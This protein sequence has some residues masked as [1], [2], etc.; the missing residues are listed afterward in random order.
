L[1]Y[2]GVV[3]AYNGAIV[4]LLSWIWGWIH[5]FLSILFLIAKQIFGG[6]WSSVKKL[7]R[8]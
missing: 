4:S 5:L 2:G 6:I 3:H 8:F 7:V 1:I